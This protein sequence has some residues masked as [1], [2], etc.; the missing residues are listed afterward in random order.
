MGENFL[1]GKIFM[2]RNEKRGQCN[3]S[4]KSAFL[5]INSFFL[6]YKCASDDC[7]TNCFT[8]PQKLEINQ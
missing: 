6:K 8:L 5:R 7:C 3:K 2:K 4:E 1:K